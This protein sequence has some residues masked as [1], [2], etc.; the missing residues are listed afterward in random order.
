MPRSLEGPNVPLTPADDVL[1]RAGGGA[2]CI[3][4][5]AV[6]LIAASQSRCVTSQ[7]SVVVY[8]Q[9]MNVESLIAVIAASVTT[10]AT[11]FVVDARRRDAQATKDARS[12]MPRNS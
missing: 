8:L 11:V 10:L 2:A 12:R 3:I 4:F 6:D 5:W 9:R 7:K 1:R